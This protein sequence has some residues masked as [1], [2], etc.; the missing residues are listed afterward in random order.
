LLTL[1][2]SSADPRYTLKSLSSW[3]REHMTN[4]TNF[5]PVLQQ[6]LERSATL[7]NQKELSPS[8]MRLAKARTLNGSPTHHDENDS[9]A[10]R[11]SK[12]MLWMQL[13]SGD[14]RIDK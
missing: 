5:L 4:G 11:Q 6:S 8:L 7:R 13:A 3:N 12:G 2:A 9:N 14:L 10:L 1:L